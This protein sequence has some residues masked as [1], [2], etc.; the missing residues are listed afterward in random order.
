LFGLDISSP[1]RPK[2]DI[3]NK[4]CP[5]SSDIEVARKFLLSIGAHY[6][7]LMCGYSLGIEEVV[8]WMR[9]NLVFYADEIDIKDEA[10]KP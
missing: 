4:T 5:N 1:R 9:V 10:D 7:S 6:Y 2:R 8:N 3:I